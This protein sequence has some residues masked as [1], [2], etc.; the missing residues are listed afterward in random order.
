MWTLMLIKITPREFLPWHSGLK[1]QLQEFL[2]CLSRLR[3]WHSDRCDSNP[4]LLLLWLWHRPA[5][6]GPNP[7]LWLILNPYSGN[8][9]IFLI[10]NDCSFF[11]FLF[12]F[13]FV[14]LG[15]Y[16]WH[17]EV[18][19]LDLNWSCSH[20]ATPQHCICDLHHNSQQCPILNPLS[21]ARDQNCILM[22]TSRIC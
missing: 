11:F 3:T 20:R 2:L 7:Q 10:S 1:I 16:L 17:M 5:A 4:A 19:G 21:E 15:Q 18:P 9:Q 22:D 8:F 12:F 6:A 14:F 13:F